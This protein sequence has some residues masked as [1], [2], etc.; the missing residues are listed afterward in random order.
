VQASRQRDLA[1]NEEF[2]ISPVL[3]E[4]DN[5]TEAESINRV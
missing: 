5:Y 4:W 1:S 2:H 3:G